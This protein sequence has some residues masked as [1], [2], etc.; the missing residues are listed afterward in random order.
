M[1]KIK[2]ALVVEGRYDKN[3]LSQIIDAPIFVTNGFGIFNNPETLS[4]LRSVAERRGLIV[5]TDS[6]GGGLVI[7]NY[8]KGAIPP[9]LV[10]HAYIPDVP[11][12]EKRKAAPGKEGKLGVEGMDPATLLTALKNAGATFLD[13]LTV[14]AA[15][16]R[17]RT[18]TANQITKTDLFELGLSGGADS[19]ARRKSLQKKLGFPENLSANAL[20]T[21]LNCVITREA[22]FSLLEETKLDSHTM[23]HYD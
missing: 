7:R 4:L 14:G 22:L 19:K 1:L 18:A 2:E 15:I 3:T 5:L 16:G 8:L 17:P 20:L 12:K 6:D 21:A 10:K 23:N 11:G 13:D 9:E